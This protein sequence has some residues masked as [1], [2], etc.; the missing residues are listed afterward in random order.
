MTNLRKVE[1]MR[2]KSSELKKLYFSA[3]NEIRLQN[4]QLKQKKNRR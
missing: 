3:T 4:F 2:L 1:E